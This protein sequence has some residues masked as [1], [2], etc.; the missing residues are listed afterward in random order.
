MSEDDIL[1]NRIKEL[2]LKAYNNSYY[3]FM[4][5]LSS[6]EIS[7]LKRLFITDP[8][9]SGLSYKLYGGMDGCERCMAAFGNEDAFGYEC[10]FPIQCLHIKPRMQKYADKLAHR[11]ILGAV[12]NLGTTRNNIGDIYLRDNTAYL[13]CADTMTEF[14]IDNLE[15]VKHTPVDCSLTNDDIEITINKESRNILVSSLRV[16][17]LIA[18]VYKLSRNDAQTLV[19]NKRVF[20][21]QITCESAGRTLKENDL[22]TVRG[23]GRFEYI[24]T[25]KETKKGNLSI[26]VSIWC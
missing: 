13:F 10:E 16:D 15:K 20:I 24:A 26:N 4:G 6:A 25:A 5:F 11:D 14:I 12:L 23:F 3:T 2:A 17:N 19:K 9:L 21:N 18:K 7:L 8:E 22:V 1:I